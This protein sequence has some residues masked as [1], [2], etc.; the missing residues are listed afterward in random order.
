MQSTIGGTDSGQPSVGAGGFG[1]GGGALG[2]A[3]NDPTGSLTD[4]HE[5][6]GI[7]R[8]PI[9]LDLSGQGIAITQLTS[10]NQFATA[11]AKGRMAWVR[12]IAYKRNR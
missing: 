3:F 1:F 7:G 10:S 2:S 9:V 8:E 5:S 11:N 12:C 6:G 4:P